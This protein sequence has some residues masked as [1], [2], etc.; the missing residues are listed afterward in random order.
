MGLVLSIVSELKSSSACLQWSGGTQMSCAENVWT[1]CKTKGC[2]A[3]ALS[4]DAFVLRWSKYTSLYP[5]A[6]QCVTAAGVG[7]AWGSL[8]PNG[9]DTPQQPPDTFYR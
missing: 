4:K 8:Q 1:G 5:V 3:H 2:A 7:G 6:E 9:V